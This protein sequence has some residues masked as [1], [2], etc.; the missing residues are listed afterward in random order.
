VRSGR[1]PL[2][3]LAA[4]AGAL[5]AASLAGLLWFGRPVAPAGHDLTG[6]SWQLVAWTL[7][8]AL[9]TTTD[10]TLTFDGRGDEPYY[11]GSA[12]INN[13]RG[14]VWVEANGDIEFGPAI[15]TQM[16]GPDQVMR[17]E[18]AYLEALTT[19]VRYQRAE[20]QLTLTGSDATELSFQLVSS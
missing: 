13:F 11:S 20:A 8:T 16:G 3:W 7:D 10:I 19:V 5:V 9:P 15:A 4:A 6:T 12:G 14:R 18:S 17:A 2:A 1:A